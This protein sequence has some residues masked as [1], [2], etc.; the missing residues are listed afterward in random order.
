MGCCSMG[1]G[2]DLLQRDGLLQRD[3]LEVVLLIW[4]DAVVQR[5]VLILFSN[6]LL[7][8]KWQF[9]FHVQDCMSRFYEFQKA[10]NQNVIFLCFF[11]SCI[12]SFPRFM[13]AQC[14][15]FMFLKK[16]LA[17][18]THLVRILI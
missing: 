13:C 9:C 4:C 8:R 1:M 12:S 15:F 11:R 6:S 5:S 14:A 3:L 10:L 2:D 18:C 16:I 17:Q 7:L